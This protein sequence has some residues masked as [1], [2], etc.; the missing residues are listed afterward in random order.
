MVLMVCT[1]HF[2][3]ARWWEPSKIDARWR[4]ENVICAI[5]VARKGRK[6]KLRIALAQHEIPMRRREKSLFDESAAM[7]MRRE[8]EQAEQLAESLLPQRKGLRFGAHRVRGPPARGWAG[9]KY[10][11][12][13]GAGGNKLGK[14]VHEPQQQHITPKHIHLSILMLM[15]VQAARHFMAR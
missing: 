12:A 6:G 1:T 5:W 7:W 2:V 11:S 10:L 8:K 15:C 9:C 13:R 3:C 14:S 4:N